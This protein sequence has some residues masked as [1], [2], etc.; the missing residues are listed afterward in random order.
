MAQ[1][2]GLYTAAMQMEALIFDADGTL[3]D[4]EVPG[5]DVLHRLMAEHGLHME[6]EAVHD[7]FRGVRMADVV[8]WIAER[9][10]EPSPESHA[11]FMAMTREGMAE[12]FRQ[13]LEPMPGAVDLLARLAVPHCV[14]TNGPREKVEL[15]LQMC[16]LRPWFGERVFSAY[17]VGVFKP[18]PGLFIHA[19]RALGAEPTRCAVVED[20]ATGIAAGL[21]AGM[22]VFAVCPP[23]LVPL[24]HQNQVTFMDGLADLLHLLPAHALR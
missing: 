22:K 13:G 11:R 8:S 9:L 16:G 24:A 2:H 21:A 10:N 7:Q 12:R 6:R 4:S 14:A 1:Y 17:E 20:S 15:T 19:A 23:H 18:E 5:L 3:V